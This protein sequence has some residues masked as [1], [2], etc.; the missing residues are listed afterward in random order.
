MGDIALSRRPAELSPWALYARLKGAAM[1]ELV[2]E[3]DDRRVMDGQAFMLGF[4]GYET[5]SAYR[6][7]HKFAT[8]GS[9]AE[10]SDR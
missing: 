8:D 10:G 5:K 6:R 4:Q 3:F 9:K 1:W 2:G 7:D